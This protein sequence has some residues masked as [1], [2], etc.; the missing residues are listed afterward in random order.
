MMELWLWI[1]RR[2]SQSQPGRG[3]VELVC[4]RSNS[5]AA[6]VLAVST[7]E[8]ASLDG[9]FVRARLDR[10]RVCF[11]SHLVLSVS[12]A[13]ITFPSNMTTQ[14]SRC[15]TCCIVSDQSANQ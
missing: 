13:L 14:A 10:V 8:A 1:K 3:T 11:V 9:N 5:L 15:P 2:V 7:M 12:S 6:L 4:L